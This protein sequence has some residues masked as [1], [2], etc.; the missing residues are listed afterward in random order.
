MW[1]TVTRH[2]PE[3]VTINKNKKMN[4]EKW[5][6]VSHKKKSLEK[7]NIIRL[8]QINIICDIIKSDSQH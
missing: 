8:I 3:L 2:T 7:K 4:K 5:E 6:D 1:D